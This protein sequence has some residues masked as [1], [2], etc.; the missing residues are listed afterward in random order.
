MTGFIF[1]NFAHFLD[2][3]EYNGDHNLRGIDSYVQLSLKYK[4]R[5]AKLNKDAFN[6]SKESSVRTYETNQSAR[7]EIYRFCTGREE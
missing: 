4:D 3:G 5:L 6:I 7:D 2:D 1:Y